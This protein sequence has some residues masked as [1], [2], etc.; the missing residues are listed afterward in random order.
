MVRY[1]VSE[2]SGEVGCRSSF[3][4][5][6]ERLA[7]Q[8]PSSSGDEQTVYCP[9]GSTGIALDQMFLQEQWCNDRRDRYGRPSRQ[10]ER[11]ADIGRAYLALCSMPRH[12]A[13]VLYVLHGDTP[14]AM[15][16]KALWE[17]AV[18][19]EYRRLARM[20]PAYLALGGD[21][22]DFER[23][24]DRKRVSLLERASLLRAVGAECEAMIVAA[25]RAYWAAL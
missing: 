7:A 14:P 1:V 6:A 16:A 4:A 8:A 24:I 22:L 20:A 23:R 19:A 18:D 12:H 17:K 25:T 10:A 9:S 5:M 21:L 15:P 11:R 2:W 13:R 3:G